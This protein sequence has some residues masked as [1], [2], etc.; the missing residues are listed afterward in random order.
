MQGVDQPGRHLAQDRQD[1]HDDRRVADERAQRQRDRAPE[2]VLERLA[3]KKAL[4]GPGVNVAD[5]A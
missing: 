3:E 2:A 1:Q 4:N 5:S